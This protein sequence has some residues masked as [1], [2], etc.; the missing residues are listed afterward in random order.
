MMLRLRK[1]AYGPWCFLDMG[2]LVKCL[3]PPPPDAW[4]L[5]HLETNTNAALG[6]YVTRFNEALDADSEIDD[7]ERQAV[8]EE[9]LATRIVPAFEAIDSLEEIVACTRSEGSGQPHPFGWYPL[10]AIRDWVAEQG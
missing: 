5:C 8:L 6:G 10:R 7:Q 9:G 4:T 1:S 3:L 2:V